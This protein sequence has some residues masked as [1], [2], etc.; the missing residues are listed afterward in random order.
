MVP[1]T[2][3]SQPIRIS[4]CS[5]DSALVSGDEL[6][7]SVGAR[8]DSNFRVSVLIAEIPVLTGFA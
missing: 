7:F 3:L 2:L 4:V 8:I 5:A 6:V 1:P